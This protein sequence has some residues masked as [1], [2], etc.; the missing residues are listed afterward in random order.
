MAETQSANILVAQDAMEAMQKIGILFGQM[1]L[2]LAIQVTRER[3]ATMVRQQDVWAALP[4][5][6]WNELLSAAGE[7]QH[8]SWG[9]W[10]NPAA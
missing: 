6:G 8:G 2:E 4:R 3:Q 9:R 1:L 5:L 10:R 7:I